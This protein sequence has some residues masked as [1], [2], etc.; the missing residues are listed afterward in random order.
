MILSHDEMFLTI[1]L[2]IFSY[3]IYTV[4]KTK[5][6]TKQPDLALIIVSVFK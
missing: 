3:Y 2:C 6:K 1:C 4:K 5:N